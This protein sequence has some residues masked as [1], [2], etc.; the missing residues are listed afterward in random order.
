MK[1]LVIPELTSRVS[2]R[3]GP[4]EYQGDAPDGA[5]LQRK[6]IVFARKAALV[7]DLLR[8]AR[9]LVAPQLMGGAVMW[10]VGSLLRDKV[11]R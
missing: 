7:T 2:S 5:C 11:H 1:D 9:W 4:Y 3:G 6:V 10:Q 8:L